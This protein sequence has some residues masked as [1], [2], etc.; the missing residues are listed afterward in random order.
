MKA[1]QSSSHVSILRSLSSSSQVFSSPRVRWL[2]L[3]TKTVCGFRNGDCGTGSQNDNTVGIPHGFVIHGIKVLKGNEKVTKVIDVEN[4]GIDNSRMLRLWFQHRFVPSEL[5]E[6]SVCIKRR[7]CLGQF[8]RKL[9][10]R[11][12]LFSIHSDEWKSFQSQP[13]TALRSYALSWNPCQ[14]DSLNLP[15][16][17]TNF[18]FAAPFQQSRIHYHVLILNLQKSFIQLKCNKNVI[19]Q[20][21]QVHVKFSNS[22]NHKLP[23]HQRSSK[24]NQESSSEEIVNQRNIR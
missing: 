2:P 8:A 9:T 7:I 1:V 5:L 3:I 22:D 15:D 21:A 11:V 12:I 4:L 17:G 14:G 10:F 23:H 20:K 16:T 24:L 13:Q 18:G 6:A 19:S